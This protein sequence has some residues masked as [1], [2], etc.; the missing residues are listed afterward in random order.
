MSVKCARQSLPSLPLLHVWSMMAHETKST[1]RY[2]DCCWLRNV[3][4]SRTNLPDDSSAVKTTPAQTKPPKGGLSFGWIEFKM[5]YHCYEF[6]M[7]VFLH[8]STVVKMAANPKIHFVG[9]L[10]YVSEI[11]TKTN[12]GR[13]G[14]VLWFLLA[15]MSTRSIWDHGCSSVGSHC[16][17]N[18][19]FKTWG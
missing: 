13:Y 15:S 16:S 7:A 2:I 19:T 11:H 18:A 5:H 4:T 14:H 6:K 9:F 17:C 8:I 12:S 1:H 3:S 10:H